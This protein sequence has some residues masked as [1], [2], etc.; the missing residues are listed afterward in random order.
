MIE[1]TNQ[2]LQ[3]SKLCPNCGIPE[4]SK[5]PYFVPGEDE[6]CSFC[7]GEFY[8]ACGNGTTEHQLAVDGVCAECR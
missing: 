5:E 8:C 4:N 7:S 3:I 2:L 6:E 1:I